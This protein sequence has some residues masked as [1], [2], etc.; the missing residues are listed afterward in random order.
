MHN[1]S[2]GRCFRKSC[3]CCSEIIFV[4]QEI[5]NWNWAIKFVSWIW[6][7]ALKRTGSTILPKIIGESK[8]EKLDQ[9]LT[10]SLPF[11]VCIARVKPFTTAVNNFSANVVSMCEPAIVSKKLLK[12]TT[13]PRSSVEDSG[14]NYFKLHVLFQW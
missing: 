14:C 9:Y 5:V 6:S 11:C 1:L 2:G 12:N 4:T 8:I 7:L 13:Y 3:S 10:S